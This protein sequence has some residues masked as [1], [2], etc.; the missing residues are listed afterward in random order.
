M[1]TLTSFQARRKTARNAASQAGGATAPGHRL[2]ESWAVQWHGA[3]ETA[4]NQHQ[5]GVPL[6]IALKLAGLSFGKETCCRD[7]SWARSELG[8]G[9]FCVY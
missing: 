9:F 5:A 4:S 3:S 2:L 6:G 1:C 8:L 7:C